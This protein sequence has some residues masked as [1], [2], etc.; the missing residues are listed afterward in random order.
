M[1][2]DDRAAAVVG[3]LADEYPQA[4][5]ELDYTTPWELLVATVLSAQC[6]DERGNRVTPA[7]FDRWPGP[8]EL[9]ASAQQDLEEVIRSTGLFRSKAANLRE[10]ARRVAEEA[11]GEVPRDAEELVSLPGVGRVENFQVLAAHLQ[12]LPGRPLV[13]LSAV[14]VIVFCEC[15]LNRHRNVSSLSRLDT[16][17]FF[18]RFL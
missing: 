12:V 14:G 7:I 18:I 2:P 13:R 9:A 16:S 11:A 8:S 1:R 17:A 10:T 4:V 15:V 5:C 6:T 3:L